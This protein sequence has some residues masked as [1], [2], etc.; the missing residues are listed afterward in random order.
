MKIAEIKWD[1]DGEVDLELPS[2]IEIPDMEE[3]QVADYL[4]DCFGFCIFSFSVE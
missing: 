3:D 4:S 1:T 2:E